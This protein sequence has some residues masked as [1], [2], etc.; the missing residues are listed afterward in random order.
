MSVQRPAVRAALLLG[1]LLWA[2]PSFLQSA[3]AEPASPYGTSR[4]ASKAAGSAV[5][6]G[7]S[8]VGGTAVGLAFVLPS[9]LLLR[10]A[11]AALV[12]HR[13][14]THKEVAEITVGTLV[15]PIGIYLALREM[16]AD[17]PPLD[18]PAFTAPPE[19]AKAGT[20]GTRAGGTASANR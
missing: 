7:A 6:T 11:Q 13:Q 20:S 10:G 15:P 1:G 8:I 9:A 5:S 16:G 17:L 18:I 4:T 2:L 12:E 19:E 3:S 14:L